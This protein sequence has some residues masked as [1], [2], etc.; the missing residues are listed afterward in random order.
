MGW[1]VL[2]IIFGVLFWLGIFLYGWARTREK[3]YEAQGRSVTDLM[4]PVVGIGVAVVA[5]VLWVLISGF[6]MLH[7]VGQR[8]VAIVY[9]FSGTISGKKDPGVVMTW[10]WQ[11]VK[12]E[13]VGIQHDEWIFGEGN[14]AVSNDQ[15]PIFGRLSINYQIDSV[16]VVDLYK[17]VGASWK[18]IIIDARVPQVFKEITATFPTPAITQQREK[19]RQDTRERLTNEL[20]PYDIRV[21]DV[22]ITNLGFSRSYTDAIEAKQKQVQD[23]ERAKAKVQEAKAEAD[24]KAAIADGE[25]R[26]NIAIARGDATANRLRQR[27]LTPRLIQWEAIQ[28]LNPKAQLIICPPGAVCVPNTF[29]PAGGG[30]GG[31]P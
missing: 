18:T 2:T 24:Q 9:N 27:S 28:K 10:P 19:L 11:H 23:A 13:N 14:S 17:R 20:K 21:V 26:A 1:I 22:F 3:S 25:A 30:G 31:A 16:N 5:A 29:I 12:K 15:Q 6:L 8:Q 7:T 4:P